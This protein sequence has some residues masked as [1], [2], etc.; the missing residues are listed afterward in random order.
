VSGRKP[1]GLS[2]LANNLV[3]SEI[4]EAARESAR[5]GKTVPLVGR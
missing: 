3:V 4:L 5:I 2:S 1:D